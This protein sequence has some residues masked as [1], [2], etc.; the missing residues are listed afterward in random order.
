MGTPDQINADGLAEP[1]NQTTCRW[2]QRSR[3]FAASFLR[4]F[5]SLA[6]KPGAAPIATS[7]T[8]EIDTTLLTEYTLG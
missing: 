4:G 8:V 1:H 7:K 6:G 3:Q 2:W 5:A